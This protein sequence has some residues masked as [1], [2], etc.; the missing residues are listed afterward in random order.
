MERVIFRRECD[1]YHNGTENF[2][3]IFPDD[4]AR[5]GYLN[6]VGFY[7]DGYGGAVFEPYTECSYGY[8][9]D[10]TRRVRKDSA[11]AIWC[12]RMIEQRYGG[13]YCVMEKIMR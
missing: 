11:D 8:Y 10:K 9:R 2:L 7:L 12:K 3:A 5:P 1:L 13:E 6:C 4:P